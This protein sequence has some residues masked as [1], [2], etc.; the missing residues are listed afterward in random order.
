MKNNNETGV[1]EKQILWMDLAGI[2]AYIMFMN[3]IAYV[4][5]W[6]TLAIIVVNLTLIPLI[7]IT[8]FRSKQLQGD[9][10]EPDNEKLIS[11]IRYYREMGFFTQYAGDPDEKIREAILDRYKAER[12]IID[13]SGDEID[14]YALC[15]DNYRVRMI[16]YESL[17]EE[18]NIIATYYSDI[19]SNCAE[20]S[21]GMF[22]PTEI[23]QAQAVDEDLI[24]ITFMLNGERRS[25]EILSTMQ[26][27]EMSLI[28][29]INELINHTGYRF[30]NLLPFPYVCIAFLARDEAKKIKHDR[31]LKSIRS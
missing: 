21:K 7:I 9:K 13:I 30:Y 12:E 25:F 28:K 15:F 5:E 17:D 6:P 29:Y 20:I 16:P 10:S 23:Y 14:K 3:L 19:V 27:P 18:N 24:T 4:W 31:G 1:I 11:A 22:Q 8:I 26:D 2:V